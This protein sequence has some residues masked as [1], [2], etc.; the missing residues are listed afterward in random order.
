M[1]AF[2]ALG[3]QPRGGIIR[4]ARQHRHPK[5]PV[6]RHLAHAGRMIDVEAQLGLLEFLGWHHGDR[7]GQRLTAQQHV[8]RHAAPVG[9][10]HFDR[11]GFG[12]D[13]DVGADHVAALGLAIGRDHLA[14]V[15][16]LG[17]AGNREIVP[18][19]DRVD[20]KADLGLGRRAEAFDLIGVQRRGARAGVDLGAQRRQAQVG[21]RYPFFPSQLDLFAHVSCPRLP[22]GA[23]VAITGRCSKERTGR[24]LGSSCMGC[25]LRQSRRGSNPRSRQ[26]PSNRA[27]PGA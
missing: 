21:Q 1:A 20:G 19:G 3:H 4:L 8:V 7:F 2:L 17:R 5:R 12:A 9:E 13:L 16:D 6:R 26:M 25:K 22:C 15:D 23:A 11:P 24:G 27:N 18:A 10:R 14:P